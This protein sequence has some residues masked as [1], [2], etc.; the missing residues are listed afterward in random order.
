MSPED[1]CSDNYVV[2]AHPIT[3]HLYS[4]GLLKEGEVK[5]IATVTVNDIFVTRLQIEKVYNFIGREIPSVINGGLANL[6]FLK[7]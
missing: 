2:M 3:E 1:Y 7:R 4:S 5:P 6:N